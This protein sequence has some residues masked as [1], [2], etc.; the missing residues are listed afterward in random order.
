M[1]GDKT[2]TWHVIRVECN[3]AQQFER[4]WIT[5]VSYIA[6]DMQ[7]T[8]RVQPFAR[9]LLEICMLPHFHFAQHRRRRVTQAVYGV[10]A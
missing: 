3:V 6:L 10:L 2:L 7:L 4:S 9:R 8:C 1:V 5:A